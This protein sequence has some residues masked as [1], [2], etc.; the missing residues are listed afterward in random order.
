MTGWGGGKQFSEI[1]EGK[2][3]QFFQILENV[4]KI[5]TLFKVEVCHHTIIPSP[6]KKVFPPFLLERASFSD[7]LPRFLYDAHTGFARSRQKRE[8]GGAIHSLLVV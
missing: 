4:G 8:G 6:E 2:S 5:A 7:N 3:S 1:E